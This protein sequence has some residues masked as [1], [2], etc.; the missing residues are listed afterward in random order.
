MK[1][2]EE[3]AHL[4]TELVAHLQAALAIT[5]DTG[6]TAVNHLLDMALQEIRAARRSWQAC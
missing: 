3:I 2:P 1:T 6:D 4:R 5:K